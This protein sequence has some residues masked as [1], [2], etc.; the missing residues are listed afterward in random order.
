MREM[1]FHLQP[2]SSFSLGQE[3][4]PRAPFLAQPLNLCFCLGAMGGGCTV[5]GLSHEAGTRPAFQQKKL[6]DVTAGSIMAVASVRGSPGPLD[7]CSSGPLK[8]VAT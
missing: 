8:Y 2:F 4:K 5:V 3:G 7:C 6:A 1:S